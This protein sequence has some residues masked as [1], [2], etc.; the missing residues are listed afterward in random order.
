M[1]KYIKIH[2]KKL[3][4][5]LHD[6]KIRVLSLIGKKNQLFIIKYWYKTLHGR[7]IDLE[8]PK[9]FDEKINWLKL[10]SDTSLWSRC[11]DKYG[12]REYVAEHGLS[13]VLNELYGVYDNADEIDFDSLP[14]SFVIKTTNGGGGKTVMIVKDK[15][16]IDVIKTRKTLNKWLK[17]P[18]CYLYG[19]YHYSMIKPRLIIEKYLQPLS[20]EYS[21]MDIKIHCFN[22]EP[23]S[24]LCCSDRQFGNSVC[25]SVYDLN[26]NLY[27]SY[28][29]EKHRTDT[30]FPKPVSFERMLEYSRVLSKGIPF[31]RVDWYEID[32]NPVFGELTFTPSAGFDNTYSDEFL[33]E[34]GD[35][36]ILPPPQKN[37]E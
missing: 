8:N 5:L 9:D 24:V 20:G 12:V 10:Y 3:Y 29:T 22:G 27:P 34:L 21:L 1:R 11:A 13:H 35:Q 2:F 37:A 7:D 16:E 14:N 4:K 23:Y 33:I 18:V 6:V 25:Y 28:I 15:S 31:V 36:L 17:T 26:W 32:G 30:V 19:E